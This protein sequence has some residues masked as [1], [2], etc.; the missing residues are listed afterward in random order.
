MKGFFT[1]GYVALA[2]INVLPGSVRAATSSPV[3]ITYDSKIVDGTN[4]AT[5]LQPVFDAARISHEIV[6]YSS[7]RDL[8][9]FLKSNQPPP[10]LIIGPT[11]SRTLDSLNSWQERLLP[12]VFI[13]PSITTDTNDYPNLRVVA[14]SPN[15]FDRIQFLHDRFLPHVLDKKFALFYEDD[16]WGKDLNEKLNLGLR[17]ANVRAFAMKSESRSLRSMLNMAVAQCAADNLHVIFV[18]LSRTIT[19]NHLLDSICEY[20]GHTAVPYTPLLVLLSNYRINGERFDRGLLATNVQ[21]SEVLMVSDVRDS[22]LENLM[23][24]TNLLLHDVAQVVSNALRQGG[25][26]EASLAQ[27]ISF[28]TERNSQWMDT[29]GPGHGFQTA[30]HE[31]I[32]GRSLHDLTMLSLRSSNGAVVPVQ[33][34]H[35]RREEV[36]T[37]MSPLISE[38]VSRN[39]AI[40]QWFIYVAALALCYFASAYT[41][42]GKTIVRFRLFALRFRFLFLVAISYAVFLMAWY[43]WVYHDPSLGRNWLLPMGLAFGAPTLLSAADQQFQRFNLPFNVAFVAS[44]LNRI[45]EDVAARVQTTPQGARLMASIQR[46]DHAAL[47]LAARRLLVSKEFKASDANKFAI[48]LNDGLKRTESLTDKETTPE[49]YKD[50]YGRFVAEILIYKHGFAWQKVTEELERLG[51]KTGAVGEPSP[52]SLNVERATE[53]VR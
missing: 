30:Y 14:T 8:Y 33:Y 6:P 10:K 49:E 11:E 50:L 23:S 47:A 3:L 12:S 24:R 1:F 26:L 31:A 5:L 44:F 36:W 9:Y 19:V 35:G 28:Y 32:V 27:I 38:F 18:A 52:N 43:V 4:I 51:I 37:V 48:W 7:A 39:A 46:N 29:E 17:E 53:L 25:S 40:Q 15:D 13:S 34:G 41:L 21:C 42:A 16:K 2:I 20:N 22:D 45:A